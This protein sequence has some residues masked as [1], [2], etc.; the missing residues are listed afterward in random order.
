MVKKI[1]DISDG[2]SIQDYYDSRLMNC[3]NGYQGKYPKVLAVCIAGLLRSATI[4]FI[5]TRGPYN[6]NTRNC[7]SEPSYALVAIDV[8]L[9]EWADFVVYANRD[10]QE[11]VEGEYGKC[12]LDGRLI[13]SYCFDLPDSFGYRDVKLVK[14]IKDKIISSGLKADLD[15]FNIK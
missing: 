1:V 12:W 9:L 15:T 7:G 13:K 10:N 2:K 4:S 8:V 11:M 14:I 5:L 3:G 6:C